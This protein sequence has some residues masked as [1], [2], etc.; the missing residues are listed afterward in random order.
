M[1]NFFADGNGRNGRQEPR[2][3]PEQPSAEQAAADADGLTDDDSGSVVQMTP[4][5][6]GIRSGEHLSRVTNQQIK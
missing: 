3:P 4:S 2:P 5:P 6:S 1:P